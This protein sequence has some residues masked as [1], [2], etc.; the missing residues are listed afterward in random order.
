[1]KTILASVALLTLCSV[2]AFA[3]FYVI[4]EPA[5]KRCRIVEQRPE[6]SIG[7]VIGNPFTA[8]VE[9]ESHMRTVA[10]C[11]DATTGRGGAVI[12]QRREPRG[13]VIEERGRGDVILDER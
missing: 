10:V 9:A 1:M 6:P 13:P 2:P 5:T 8:R 12:E 3:D 11:R 4:Q 7:V